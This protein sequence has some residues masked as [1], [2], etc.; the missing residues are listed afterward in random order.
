MLGTSLVFVGIT[1]LHYFGAL[2]FGFTNVFVAVKIK[3]ATKV[4]RFFVWR[5]EEDSNL[6]RL[7][8]SHAFQACAL[9]RST[10]SAY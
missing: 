5:R 7:L 1:N 6:R 4:V 9:N 3:N 8:T 10:I 2:L